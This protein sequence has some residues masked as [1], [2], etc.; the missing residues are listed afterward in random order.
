MD[1]YKFIKDCTRTES[2]PDEIILDRKA[3]AD[4]CQ[5]YMHITEIFDGY[6]KSIFY[7]RPQKLEDEFHGHLEN[8]S[9][10]VNRLKE[11]KQGET[12]PVTNINPRVLHGIVGVMTESGEL[13]QIMHNLIVNPEAEIDPIHV[14][15]EM[16]DGMASGWYPAIIHDALG[17]D[18]VE[19]HDKLI[20]KLRARYPEGFSEEL[21]I[22]RDLTREREE[23]E[24]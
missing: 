21:A 7:N 22:S 1:L 10:I 14:Q 13:C 17:L 16:G 9:E 6:K 20:R 18:P 19:T 23:L 3:F 15:E 2:A 12:E 11:G 24:R 8:I 5:L 4:L